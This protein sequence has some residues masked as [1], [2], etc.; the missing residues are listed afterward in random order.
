MAGFDTTSVAAGVTPPQGMSLGDIV[1]MARGAQAYQK[2]RELYPALVEQAKAQSQQTQYG[3][4]KAGVE[5]N[6]LKQNISRA[7]FGGLLNDEDFINGTPGM[8]PKLQAT[9]DKLVSMGITPPD[10]GKGFQQLVELAGTNPKQAYQMIRNGV[11]QAGG[12]ASQYQSLQASQNAPIYAGEGAAPQGAQPGVT[13][14]QMARPY[15][16]KDFGGEALPYPVRQPGINFTPGPSEAADATA[17]FNYRTDLRTKA[18]K[19]PVNKRNI[20]EVLD[21]T[22]QIKSLGIPTYGKAAEWSQAYNKFAGTDVGVKYAQLSKD[23][24]NAQISQMNENQLNT[25]AGRALQ[26]AASGTATIPPEVLTG[27]ARRQAAQN[28]ALELQSNGAEKF[29]NKFQDRNIKAFQKQWQNN[30]DSKVFELISLKNSGL[31][32]EELAA[33]AEKLLGSDPA[34]RK[35]FFEKYNNIK[36]LSETGSL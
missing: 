13:P 25:D 20:Q 10:G 34:K 30:S 31:S 21:V 33:E 7:E 22:N 8:I 5:L 1:N 23:L 4:E 29:A 28:T 17:G 11:Q 2:E 9:Y 35:K 14:Q 36:R 18:D 24:A 32:K 27:I 26:A 19:I 3:A 6:Q 15:G 16:S 12:A